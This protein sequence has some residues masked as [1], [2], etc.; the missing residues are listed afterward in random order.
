MY[1]APHHSGTALVNNSFVFTVVISWKGL[2]FTCPKCKVDSS[3]THQIRIKRFTVSDYLGYDKDLLITFHEELAE[4]RGYRGCTLVTGS[5]L[6]WRSSPDVRQ[7]ENRNGCHKNSNILNSYQLT[8][9]INGRNI[10]PIKVKYDIQHC[11][12]LKLVWGNNP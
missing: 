5:T 1:F 12:G 10:G 9:C 8:F 11:S 6:D 7:D 3:I 2:H 4:G